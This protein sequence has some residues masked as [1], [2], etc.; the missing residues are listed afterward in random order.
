MQARG[1]FAQKTALD[2]EGGDR[3]NNDNESRGFVTRASGWLRKQLL[4][5]NA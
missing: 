2:K 4:E 3:Y 1:V 5:E